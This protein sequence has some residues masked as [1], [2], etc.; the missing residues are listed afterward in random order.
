V[1]GTSFTTSACTSTAGSRECKPAFFHLHL[2]TPQLVTVPIAL[3]V[4][5]VVVEDVGERDFEVIFSE[6]GFVGCEGSVGFE[7]GVSQED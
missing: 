4:V 7:C 2:C 6:A 5:I 1:A 3:V